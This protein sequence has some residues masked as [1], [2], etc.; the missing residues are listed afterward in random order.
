MI[1]KRV[2]NNKKKTCIEVARIQYMQIMHCM[3]TGKKFKKAKKD[4][5][6]G[7]SANDVILNR[8]RAVENLLRACYHLVPTFQ[9]HS[10]IPPPK[11]NRERETADKQH[12]WKNSRNI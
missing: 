5:T 3:T 9:Q 4:I 11:R 8:S 12:V 1:L 10:K 6:F 7:Q 2:I